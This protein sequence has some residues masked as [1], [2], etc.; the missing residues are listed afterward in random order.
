MAWHQNVGAI[1]Y[2]TT[3][4]EQTAIISQQCWCR[5][6]IREGLTEIESYSL[7]ELLGTCIK[8]FMKIPTKWVRHKIQGYQLFRSIGLCHSPALILGEPVT[9]LLI[10]LSQVPEPQFIATTRRHAQIADCIIQTTAALLPQ[11]VTEE[12]ELRFGVGTKCRQKLNLASQWQWLI[13][14]IIC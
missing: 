6:V 11:T 12:L 3:H 2:T 5:L 4:S 14:V 1:T 9:E 13:E 7:P 10:V 8:T